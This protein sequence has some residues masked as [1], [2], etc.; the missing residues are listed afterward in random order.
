MHFT[1][2]FIKRPVLATV[3]NLFLLIAGYQAIRAMIVRQ[4]PRTDNAVVT[5][6]VAYPGANA[7]LVRGFVTTPLEREI[8]SADG[9]DYVESTSR[10]SFASIAVRLRLNY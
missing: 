4:Y 3:V 6:S 2:I 10:Q 9:I 7:D 1:D 8:A 5:V